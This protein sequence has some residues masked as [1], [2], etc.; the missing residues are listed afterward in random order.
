MNIFEE[1]LIKNGSGYKD[2]T[3]YDAMVNIILDDFKNNFTKD[4]Y[5]LCEKYNVNI[6]GKVTT[7]FKNDNINKKCIIYLDNT[8]NKNK[9]VF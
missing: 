8:N 7:K 3:A 6:F 2:K 1:N 9:G 4:L 5:K